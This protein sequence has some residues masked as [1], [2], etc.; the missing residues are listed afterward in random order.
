M[1]AV[2]PLMAQTLELKDDQML[3]KDEMRSVVSTTIGIA[4]NDLKEAWTDFTKDEYD[5]KFKGYGFLTNKD[6]LSAEK[7]Q[8]TEI[9]DKRMNLYTH[10]SQNDMGTEMKLFGEYGYDVFI[11][12][13]NYPFAYKEMRELVIDFLN[14]YLPEHYQNKIAVK[15][16]EV[17][18][19]KSDKQNLEEEI[20]ENI[21][22]IEKLKA[23]NEEKH[24][25]LEMQKA[26]LIQA[27]EELEARQMQMK[28]VNQELMRMNARYSS[29]R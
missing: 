1:I 17:A 13:Y 2:G 24:A 14:N 19:I 6:L 28:E 7:V 18:D 21:A 27:K 10:F 9:S 3:Y 5:I 8:V 11:N 4:P 29:S 25:L 16:E 12:K 23:E 15:S 26:D 20:E 22:E